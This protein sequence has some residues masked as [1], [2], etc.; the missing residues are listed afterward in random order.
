MVTVIIEYKGLEQEASQTEFSR[1]PCKDERIE[2]DGAE[3][4]V[5]SVTHIAGGEEAAR[6]TVLSTTT[7][8]HAFAGR[9]QRRRG[10]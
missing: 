6:L 7:E 9:S 3:Y 4:K 1:V 10:R 2:L 8:V 5:E